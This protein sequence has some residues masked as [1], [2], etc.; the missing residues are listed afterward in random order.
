VTYDLCAGRRGVKHQTLIGEA[1]AGLWCEQGRV[2]KRLSSTCIMVKR[3]GAV[4]L[5]D[6]APCIQRHWM[7]GRFLY[8]THE[9]RRVVCEV[10][11]LI[12][13]EGYFFS[14]DCS[15]RL[16]ICLWR[17]LLIIDCLWWNWRSIYQLD[18]G[19]CRT[20]VSIVV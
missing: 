11:E 17:S 8:E 14:A 4:Y 1:T 2:G 7:R 6:G 20:R 12:S 5:V 9:R 16:W 3:T 10:H 19:D 13:G 15:S 18:R